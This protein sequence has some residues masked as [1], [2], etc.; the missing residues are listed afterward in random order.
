[1][2]A[3]FPFVIDGRMARATGFRAQARE[4]L[5]DLLIRNRVRI[6][7]AQSKDDGGFHLGVVEIGQACEHPQTDQDFCKQAHGRTLDEHGR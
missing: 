7:G 6:V 2:D 1:M 4:P 5:R 3:G